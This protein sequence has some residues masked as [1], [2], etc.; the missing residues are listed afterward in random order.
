MSENRKIKNATVTE[1]HGITFK[2]KI[3]ARVYNILTA[4]G[5]DKVEYETLTFVVFNGFVPTAQKYYAPDKNKQLQCQMGKIRNVTY[6]PDFIINDK[7]L[8]EIKGMKN[9][10]YPLKQKMFRQL[11]ETTSYM[12][13][14]V[15]TLVQLQQAI[16]IIKD[17]IARSKLVGG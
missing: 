11:L 9:D 12:F 15:H 10:V 16:K 13:F 2:S 6:T 4:S 8:I 3:E 1:S 14:E 17:D 7:Y 5:F